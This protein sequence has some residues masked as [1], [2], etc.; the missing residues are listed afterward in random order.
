[1]PPPA[2]PLLLVP[3]VAA[4]LVLLLLLLP[5]LL[6]ELLPPLP[7]PP[8][9]L[10]SVFMLAQHGSDDSDSHGIAPKLLREKEKESHQTNKSDLLGGDKVSWV[11]SITQ[12][13]SIKK[14]PARLQ[15]NEQIR[16]H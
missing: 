14:N 8:P 13:G 11:W 4:V 7:P 1:M 10:L 12:V 3:A 5:G 2:P 15:S 6:L 16:E 9:P